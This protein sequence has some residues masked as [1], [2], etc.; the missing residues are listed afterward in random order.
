MLRVPSA[1]RAAIFEME[2]LLSKNMF[3]FLQNQD[4]EETSG[5][6]IVD[7]WSTM[8]VLLQWIILGA[9]ETRPAVS[10]CRVGTSSLRKGEFFHARRM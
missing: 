3:A 1:L 8:R 2:I 9:R 4:P 6:L 5:L 7:W 10:C